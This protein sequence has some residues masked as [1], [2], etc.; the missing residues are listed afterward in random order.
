MKTKTTI[1]ILAL[2]FLAWGCATVQPGNDPIVVHAEQTYQEAFDTFD[3]LFKLDSDNRAFVLQHAPSV[4]KAIN[5]LKPK[6]KQA[7]SNVHNVLAAY[8][9]NRDANNKASLATYLATLQA[10]LNEAKTYTSQISTG[11]P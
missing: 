9:A 3:T 2:C 10:L 7:L 8:K 11:T 4:H 1:P 5:D 6:A